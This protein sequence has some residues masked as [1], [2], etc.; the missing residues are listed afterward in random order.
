MSWS[1]PADC[2][3]NS[4]YSVTV[5]KPPRDECM[6][7]FPTVSLKCEYSELL[8]IFQMIKHSSGYITNTI[9]KI[10]ISIKI[11][12]RHES[13]ACLSEQTKS[14]CLKLY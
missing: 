2:L 1:R 12:S 4:A 11:M 5:V 9:V 14:G 7:Q 6:T 10:E 3:N 8:Y 13:I